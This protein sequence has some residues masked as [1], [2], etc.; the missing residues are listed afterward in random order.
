MEELR[1][2]LVRVTRGFGG[3]VGVG[4][5][6]VATGEGVA[7]RRGERFSLQSVMKL[8]VAAAYF[9]A[10]L[11]PDSGGGVNWEATNGWPRGLGACFATTYFLPP[12]TSISW[13]GRYTPTG[14]FDFGPTT[15]RLAFV[16]KFPV[17]N[18]AGGPG[19]TLTIDPAAP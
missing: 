10:V 7:V 11:L 2:E 3:R 9:D 4:V 5:R 1:R 19:G 16:A 17:A 6:D 14:T 15:V 12:H 18:A 13:T 8:V